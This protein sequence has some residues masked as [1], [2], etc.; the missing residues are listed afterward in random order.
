MSAAKLFKILKRVFQDFMQD[1]CMRVSA[2]LAYY[3]IF[4]LPPLLILT[5]WICG[6]FFDPSDI[7]GR[8]AAEIRNVVGSEGAE[9]VKEILQRT[10]ERSSSGTYLTNIFGVLA[11]LFGASG[12]M[13]QLQTA[14]NEV[15]EVKPDP[16]EGGVWNFLSKRMLSLGMV[17]GVAFLLLVSLILTALI[18]SLSS[19]ALPD[20]WSEWSLQSVNFVVNF[21]MMTVL[22]AAIFKVLPDAE[23]AWKDVWVGAFLTSFLFEVGKF[24]MG[25]YF[26]SSSVGS[27]Y[28]VAGSL[29]LLLVWIYY[30]GM[31]L[32]LGAEFTQAWAFEMGEGIQPAEGAVQV[33][34]KT[35]H[36]KPDGEQCQGDKK[37]K[38]EMH[39][40]PLKR[41]QAAGVPIGNNFLREEDS[42]RKIE[43]VST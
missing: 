25:L 38:S 20:V 21:G 24:S 11:L 18:A 17:L 36:V 42:N 9:Q 4:A 33:V 34:E 40:E 10:G 30:S 32:L 37:S 7:E 13:V 2:A 14:L 26:A 1:N 12:V 31:I 8:V 19:W 23:V 35:I 43:K 6:I 39:K 15:W 16:D 3:T 27:V 28:G 41:T 5:L 22:F 29:V